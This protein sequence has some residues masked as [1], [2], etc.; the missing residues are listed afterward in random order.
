LGK[1][2]GCKEEDECHGEPINRRLAKKRKN[3]TK[4]WGGIMSTSSPRHKIWR[5]IQVPKDT[6]LGEESKGTQKNDESQDEL[7]S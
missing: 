4:G 2:W 3:I 6:R 5:R 1:T 7:G